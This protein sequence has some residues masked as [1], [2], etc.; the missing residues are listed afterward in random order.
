VPLIAA[1]RIA[2]FVAERALA[3]WSS[4][5]SWSSS[6]CKSCSSLYS[7]GSAAPTT[8]AWHFPETH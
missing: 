7:A 6:W 2:P 3:S 8:S 4:H 1:V 5:R